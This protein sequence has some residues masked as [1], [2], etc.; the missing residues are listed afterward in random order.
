MLRDVALAQSPATARVV[1]DSGRTVA[2]LDRRLFG[3]FL[4][5]LGRAIYGGILRARIKARRRDGFRGDVL[6]LK[7][8][9]LNV[10]IVRYPGGNF[11]SG[12][13]WLDGVG[14]ADA[15]PAVLDRAWNS[16]RDQ[17]F[18]TDEFIGLVPRGRHRAAAGRQPRHGHRREGRSR[19]VEYCNIAV[20]HALERP[21]PQARRRRAA[22]A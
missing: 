11:V 13:D 22:T 20:G 1:V 8:A 10:P 12:Y 9:T 6:E 7:S 16:D 18:G 14:P 4:E 3:S 2:T 21:A 5:H 19:C 17:Q 15:R